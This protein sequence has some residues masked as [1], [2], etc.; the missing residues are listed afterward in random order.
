MSA[1]LGQFIWQELMTTDVA[2]AKAFYGQLLGWGVENSPQMA[3][4]LWTAS[5]QVVAGLMALPDE[6][7][8]MGVPPHWMGYVYVKDVDEVVRKV[9]AL[10]GKVF[11]RGKDVPGVG[12]FAVLGD[13][14]G[15]GF[16]VLAPAEG[17]QG[18]DGPRLFGWA[19]LS[20]TDWE[21]AWKFYEEVFGWKATR[22]MEM[23]PELGTYFMFGLDSEKSMGGMSN[24]SK[25]AG[26]PA[27]WVH[28][29][30]VKDCDA[31][32]KRVPELGGQVLYGPADIP[33][34]GRMA[35]CR[36][37]QGADFALYSM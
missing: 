18:A 27:Y 2:A 31:T 35:H 17:S 8:A 9:E 11:V 29:I 30:E 19:D 13:P 36:D 37:P 10:G 15:A 1:K 14:Q 26:A 6:V 25:Q 12:R 7:R 28:Y 20:T 5:G 3:Y 24:A 34:G 4:S 23:G 22:S 21:A 32:T 33:G 16:S